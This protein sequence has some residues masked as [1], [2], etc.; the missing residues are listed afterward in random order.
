[1]TRAHP[2]TKAAG[3]RSRPPLRL[4][5]GPPRPRLSSLNG[6]G[7]LRRNPP[8]RE[9]G[10]R[11]RR[12]GGARL[13]RGGDSRRRSVVIVANVVVRRTSNLCRR[14]R[15]RETPAARAGF[16]RRRGD[17]AAAD[18]P[19]GRAAGRLAAHVAEGGREAGAQPSRPSH[20]DATASRAAAPRRPSTCSRASPSWRARWSRRRRG[21]TRHGRNSATA[22]F[23]AED[24]ARLE[25]VRE[26]RRNALVAEATPPSA[27]RALARRV[28]A[29]AANG[30]VDPMHV[31]TIAD[32]LKKLPRAASLSGWR[33]RRRDG[34]HWNGA[35]EEDAAS[36]TK[37][38]G[39]LA[40]VVAASAADLEPLQ[41]TNVVSAP[42]RPSRRVGA[43]TARRWRAVL[44]GNERHQTRRERIGGGAAP[45]FPRRPRRESGREDVRGL[46][47]VRG[48]A[49]YEKSY[50]DEADRERLA[51]LEAEFRD[52]ETTR[53]SLVTS[54]AAPDAAFDEPF[55]FFFARAKGVIDRES[56][57]RK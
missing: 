24:C 56:T 34:T 17:E 5:P 48:H 21:E 11:T 57:L 1:M 36:K 2:W 26:Q 30:D 10:F 37:S 9:T 43:R 31:A 51:A 7:T 33:E 27:P 47:L 29:L 42:R 38:M 32:A 25:R 52:A 18:R 53:S 3:A 35:G 55:F 16:R 23:D 8:R 41:V 22:G 19:R 6:R 44:A 20:S 40:R 14:G 39:H 12:L 45:D 54:A 50:G 46:E 49:G 28:A 15:A 13:T 4:A